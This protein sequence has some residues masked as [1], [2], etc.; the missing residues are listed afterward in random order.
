MRHLNIIRNEQGQILI[1]LAVA[2]PVLILFSG[3]AID[4]G[5]LYVAKAKLSTSVDAAC[6]TG[7][8]NLSQGQAT[9]S[10]LATH[11]FNANFG[12]GAPIP[13]V[14]FPTDAYGDQQ[15]N[16][17]ATA[18]VNTIFMRYVPVFAT[19]NVSD[20]AIATRGKLV[21]SIVLD[22]SGSMDS[23]HDKGGAA[24]QVAVPSFVNDFSNANDEVAMISFSSNS[25]VN[26]PMN[27]N[28]ITPITNAV[29]ALTFSGG[30]FGT[31]AGTNPNPSAA[32]GPPLSLA[33]QQ[34]DS[35]I[36]QPGQ[37][38]TKVVVYFTDGLMNTVQDTFNCPSAKLINYGGYDT[39]STTP[40]F[41]DPTNGSDWGTIST[42]GASKG[43][44]P[45]DSAR[46]Y[47][48]SASG[49]YVTTFYSQRDQK[50]E[51][52]LQSSVT[53]E[54]QYRAI[55]T[56]AALRT[57]TPIAT[58]IYVIGLGSGVS[59][60][61]QAFLGQLAND[62]AYPLTYNANQPAGLFLYVPNCPSATCTADLNT[63]FQTIAAKI[64]L[65]LT[66]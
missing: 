11:I 54:A 9:A 62:P 60:S 63:A 30:T 16:V 17:A 44:L 32:V 26:F 35:V 23:S 45:Y 46:D 56:A 42:S 28:F 22:R 20:T 10:I 33:Q 47:C 61:T 27:Y 55:L 12:A 2:L 1:M 6:L 7:M 66:Q 21:M 14:T 29:K 19:I 8:K 15:V 13:I 36:P 59:T 49:V 43:A 41:V 51:A 34:N 58:Y 3:L 24:L 18:A 25:T 64:L 65:R 50:Q 38:V 48:K 53:G 52:F 31:G 37:N 57:E 40:D 5:L 39:G 4:S